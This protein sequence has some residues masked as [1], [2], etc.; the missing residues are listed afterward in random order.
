M[1]FTKN[2]DFRWTGDEDLAKKPRV[3]YIFWIYGKIR[4]RMPAI[5]L[6]ILLNALVSGSS[7]FFALTTRSV[8]NYAMEGDRTGLI[9]STA[10]LVG[11][12]LFQFSGGI[13]SHYL[14][15]NLQE[16]MERDFKRS[17]LHTILRTDYSAICGHHS[18]DLIQR[19]DGDAAVVYGAVSNLTSSF[20]SVVV[21]LFGAL[22]AL[23]QLTPVFTVIF[24][25]CGLIAGGVTLA[26]QR[27]IKKLN[28]ASS[29]ATGRVSGFLHESISLLP[30]S[31]Y[32]TRLCG[33]PVAGAGPFGEPWTGPGWGSASG[34]VAG[35]LWPSC[36]HQGLRDWGGDGGLCVCLRT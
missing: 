18:G 17:I 28:K 6:K 33:P 35:L 19:L 4:R 20:V 21:S 2:D 30:P 36:V 7:V 5:L 8:V 10:L 11:L 27:V 25:I 3:N 15:A 29:A 26:L 12:I 1:A 34:A 31:W 23:L 22:A 9:R 32:S 13:I 24:C 16:D 14:H